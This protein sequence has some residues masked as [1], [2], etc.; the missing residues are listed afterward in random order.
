MSSGYTGKKA[1]L[2]RPPST[3]SYPWRA[4]PKYQPES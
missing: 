2:L 3:N 1:R 4:M